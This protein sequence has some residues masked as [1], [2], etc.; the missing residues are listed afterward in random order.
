MYEQQCNPVYRQV[1]EQECTTAY[2]QQCVN[3]EQTTYT[4]AYEQSCQNVP[5]QV[6]YSSALK[7]C[8]NEVHHSR[9]LTADVL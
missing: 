6:T 4:T 5:E 3:E 8:P 1:P 2:E 9:Y 7:Q